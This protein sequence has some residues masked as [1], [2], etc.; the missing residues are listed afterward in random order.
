MK[1]IGNNK[2]YITIFTQ[3]YNFMIGK[4]AMSMWLDI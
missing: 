2:Y 4:I 3:Q 1:C